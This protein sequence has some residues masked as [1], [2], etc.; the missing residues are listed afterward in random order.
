VTA[1]GTTEPDKI[2]IRRAVPADAAAVADVYLASFASAY[3][4]PLAHTDE[5]VRDWL[6]QVVLP[7]M[8][9]WVAEDDGRVVAMMVLDD[10]GI[11]HL[12]VE[13]AWHRRGIGSRLVEFAK[14]RRPKGLEL[15]TFQV[16]DRARRFYERHGFI[17]A[18]LGDGSANE[19]RQPDVRYE[20]RP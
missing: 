9:T 17:V 14:S 10:A 15:Y 12:Y 1:P 7:Q 6:A 2:S 5:Q 19:E 3:D 20:W 4:F 18:G 13:P 11:D 8:E 16:N